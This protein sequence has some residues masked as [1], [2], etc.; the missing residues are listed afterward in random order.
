MSVYTNEAKVTVFPF[1]RQAEGGEVVIGRLETGV[2]LALPPDAVEILDVLAAGETVG[3]AQEIYRAKYG[4]TPEMEEF[5]GFLQTKGFVQP[6]AGKERALNAAGPSRASAGPRQPR[7]HFANIPQSVANALFG[8]TA[9][10][11]AALLVALA[12]AGVWRA[13]V[14]FPG[15]SALYFR[16]DRTLMMLCLVFMGYATV[17]LHE[18][19]H[20]VAARARGVSSR[21]GISRRMWVLVAETDMTGLW[22]VPKAQRYL[23]MLAG[24]L[25]DVT[26]AAIML[27]VLFAAFQHWISLKIPVL[28]L[29]SAMCFV[30]LMRLLWQC[31][32]FVRT[33]FY[34]VIANF[35]GCKSLMRDT[36]VFIQNQFRRLISKPLIDQSGLP[37]P[38]LRVIRAYAWVWL[39]GRMIALFSLFFITIP[40]SF[41]YLATCSEE[42]RAGFSGGR[43]AFFDALF[44]FFFILL[45]IALGLGWWLLS[46]FK[47][48]RLDDDK[49]AY[50][51]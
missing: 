6:A 16:H 18:M 8:R 22:S 51:T 49:R 36:Q 46:L 28:E 42:L 2:F 50:A 47:R 45:P 32:F 10:T 4:E 44:I 34:Y 26:S 13:P 23:P 17:F 29:L 33:D 14:I 37:Q 39:L 3:R 40:V 5:L 27:L 15:R 9:L 1:T 35:F 43:Y 41:R 25:V 20:L 48:W 24:P 11:I 12:A 31:F 7:Y 30:Y 21:L 38:E 19:G